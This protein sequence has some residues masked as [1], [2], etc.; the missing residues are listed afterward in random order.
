MDRCP[1]P[2]IEFETSSRQLHEVNLNQISL[3]LRVEHPSFG[4]QPN[5]L[6]GRRDGV[7]VR[8]VSSQ[9]LP[10]CRAHKRK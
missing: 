1:R 5:E 6:I 10:G 4:K 9:G 2:I 8:P 7:Q 3:P